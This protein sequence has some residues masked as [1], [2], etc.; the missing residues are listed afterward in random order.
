MASWDVK[1][2][3]FRAPSRKL[4]V[5]SFQAMAFQD[6]DGADPAPPLVPGP[7]LP[8]GAGAAPPLPPL[9]SDG[10]P[11]P[12]LPPTTDAKE[13]VEEEEE[14]PLVVA[15]RRREEEEQAL[16]E[17]ADIHEDDDPLL[18]VG[19]PAVDSRA[20]GWGRSMVWE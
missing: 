20:A 9:P 11:Q 16:Q 2:H 3:F 12:P 15:Q 18:K 17:A 10:G 5:L 14:D 4:L 6:D 19:A 13:Q 8:P 7:P 1:L